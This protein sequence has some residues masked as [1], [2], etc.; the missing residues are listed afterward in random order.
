MLATTGLTR[1]AVDHRY[2][3]YLDSLNVITVFAMMLAVNLVV[4]C[5]NTLIVRVYRRICIDPT[6][7]W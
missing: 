7:Q 6:V 5:L 3:T 2:D 4:H 1:L